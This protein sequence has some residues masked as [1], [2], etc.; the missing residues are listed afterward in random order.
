[1]GEG[2]AGDVADDEGA[3][4]DVPDRVG[5]DD[6]EV[7]AGGGAEEVGRRGAQRVGEQVGELGLLLED[8]EAEVVGDEV[9]EGD[10]DQ[11]VGEPRRS[12]FSGGAPRTVRIPRTP[13][14]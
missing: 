14:R 1:M 12:V 6:A 5:A 4:L 7:D 8:E 11:R 9:G 13:S 10:R 2:Q 3:D